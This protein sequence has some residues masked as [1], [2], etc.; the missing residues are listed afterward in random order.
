MQFAM[1]LVPE[2]TD[3]VHVEIQIIFRMV[4]DLW[5]RSQCTWIEQIRPINELRLPYC[6]IIQQAVLR[7]SKY[8]SADFNLPIFICHGVRMVPSASYHLN[9]EQT[10]FLS[11]STRIN[12]VVYIKMTGS[13]K[14]CPSLPILMAVCITVG[15]DDQRSH[16]IAGVPGQL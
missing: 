4:N 7:L 3:R 16:P 1:W 10:L 9:L 2:N 8:S 12:D 11:D 13:W 5:W 15:S 14:L 6:K